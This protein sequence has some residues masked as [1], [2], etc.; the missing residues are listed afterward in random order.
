MQQSTYNGWSNR[1][2]WLAY[3]W[4]TNDKQSS[5]LLIEA[6]RLQG[7]AYEQGQWLCDRYEGSLHATLNYDNAFGEASLFRDLI[8]D[9]FDRINW[10]E[11]V[12]NS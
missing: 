7:E 4:L 11:I 3:A 12:T 5:A 10:T 8:T 1:E 9:A 6:R 2:T